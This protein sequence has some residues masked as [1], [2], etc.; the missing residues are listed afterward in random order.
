[1][2]A[3]DNFLAGFFLIMIWAPIIVLWV[4]TLKD[5]FQRASSGWKIALWALIIIILPLVGCLLYWVL[6]PTKW[7]REVEAAYQQSVQREKAA[8]PPQ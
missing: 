3:M 6:N 8:A 2:L 4:F 5:L 7:N 1:V